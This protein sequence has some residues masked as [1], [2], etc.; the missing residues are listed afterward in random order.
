MIPGVAVAGR[1]AQSFE[2]RR[3]LVAGLSIH[4]ERHAACVLRVKIGN[5]CPANEEV[6][7]ICRI[8]D[9]TG[10]MLIEADIAGDEVVLESLR[11]LKKN[12][13]TGRLEM[14]IVMVDAGIDVRGV[15]LARAH[16]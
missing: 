14:A 5:K 9:R 13:D 10:A 3:E 1:Q 8:K 11:G 2:E 15:S 4:S 7:W 16:L 6:G 12:S